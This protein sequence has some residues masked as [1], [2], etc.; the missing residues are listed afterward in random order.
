MKKIFLIIF[1][2]LFLSGCGN[3]AELDK[4]AIVT[5][6][7]IDKKGNDYEISYLVANSP[8]GQ[9]SSKEGEAKTTV[10]SGTGKTIPD[11]AMVIEQKSP[12]KIYLGHVNV[13]IISEDIAKDGFFKVADWLFR[14]PETRKQFYLLQAKNDKAKDIIKII[15]PL[16]SFPSQSIA[17]LLESNRDS[18]SASTTTTYNN[19]VGYVLE[20]GA[21]PILPTITIH[22]NIKKGSEQSNIETTEPIAYLTLGPL[23]IFKEDKLVG[24][25]TTKES[26]LINLIQNKIK[27][28]K[29]SLTFK[30]DALSIDSYNLKTKLSIEDESHI[31]LTITG[32]GNIYNINSNI[33]ISNPK[34]IKKIENLW[35]KSLQ[36]SLKKLIRKMQDKYH[37][38]IF[39]FGN[40]IYSTYPKKW[41]QL[42]KDWNNKYFKEVK[43]KIKSN[44]KIPDTGSLKDTLTEARK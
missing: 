35:N 38:D 17:T 5:G 36:K 12:K 20:E 4:L 27:E 26:E 10:Y 15:S 6:V 23:A 37:A 42:K 25:A 34:E 29:F 30:N 3:Y 9:T 31:T 22:G 13:V 14:S 18:K 19:F 7:A 24:Y 33:D 21:D 43:V 44:L 32:N 8:K 1:L 28:I 41:N 40:K 11:A 2:C 16:E 39:G